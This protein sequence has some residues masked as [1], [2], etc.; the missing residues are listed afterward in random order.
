MNIPRRQ[1]KPGHSVRV[2]LPRSSIS[3]SQ[4][5]K[6]KVTVSHAKSISSIE[7][8]PYSRTLQSL[9]MDKTTVVSTQN[10]LEAPVHYSLAGL[11][12]KHSDSSKLIKAVR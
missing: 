6:Q 4:S 9:H 8:F 10:V 5:K 12:R 3:P 1:I 2:A 7:C 11:K